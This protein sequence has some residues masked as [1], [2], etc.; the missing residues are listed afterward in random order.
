MFRPERVTAAVEDVDEIVALLDMKPEARILD[1]CCGVGRHSL[2]L[3]RR[4]FHVTG[5]DRTTKYLETAV[6]QAGEQG[7]TVE[8]V[9]DDM[10]SFCRPDTYDAVISMFTSFSYFEDPDEDRQV[11]ENACRS[12]KQGGALLV[13]THGKETLARIFQ[14]RNWEEIDG[15]LWLQERRVTQNWGWMENRWILIDGDQRIEGG[16]SHRLYAATEM[17]SLMKDCG[18][19]AVDVYGDL[20]GSPYDHTARRMVTVGRR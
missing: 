19:D 14:E 13:E 18:F 20:S 17:V 4:G 8:C 6:Q 3:A 2:E 12:L 11:I 10:R 1:L 9:Q 5:V 16:V 15:V 7:L